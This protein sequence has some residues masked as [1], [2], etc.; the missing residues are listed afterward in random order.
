MN[1]IHKLYGEMGIS[2]EVIDL[3]Q[4]VLSALSDRIEDIDRNAEYLSLIHI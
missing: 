1:E 4:D 3:S 2:G